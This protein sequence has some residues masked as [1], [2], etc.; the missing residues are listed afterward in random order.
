VSLVAIARDLKKQVD[1]LRTVVL[2]RRRPKRLGPKSRSQ[3]NAF[4]SDLV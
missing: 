3:E 1:S 4:M 2:R